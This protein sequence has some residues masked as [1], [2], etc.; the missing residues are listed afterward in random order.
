MNE[1]ALIK[2]LEDL[3]AELQEVLAEVNKEADKVKERAPLDEGDEYLSEHFKLSE[4][5]FSQTASR[6]GIDNTPT[7]KHKENMKLLCEHV[8]E[9]IREHYGRPIKLSS[10]YRSRALNKA[11][12][13]S[14]TSDHSMGRAADFEIAGIANYD[15]AKWIE[16][17]LNYKQL[18]LE[19]YTPGSPNSGWIHVSYA[20][21]PHKNQELTAVKRGGRTRYLNG[22]I[23]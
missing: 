9:P 15:V 22:L 6:E 2:I 7:A 11:V 10:G 12:G 16:K 19:F 21:S 5:T 3:F 18:I 23:K 17:N 13:G 1:D 4:F 20:G 8:L 14:R